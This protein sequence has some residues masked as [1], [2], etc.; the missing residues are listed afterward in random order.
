MH[1]LLPSGHFTKQAAS[2]CRS[3]SESVRSWPLASV[4][5]VGATIEST[6][7]ITAILRKSNIAAF[8][9]SRQIQPGHE[10]AT[11]GGKVTIGAQSSAP[12]LPS[13]NC[14]HFL[15]ALSQY[16]LRSSTLSLRETCTFPAISRHLVPNKRPSRG[17][18]RCAPRPG[19]QPSAGRAAHGPDCPQGQWTLLNAQI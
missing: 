18:R 6:D 16:S 12:V 15:A 3:P 19:D 17:G 1:A 4:V 5:I 14:V 10:K 11:R 7:K 8:P 13:E 2:P 9:C